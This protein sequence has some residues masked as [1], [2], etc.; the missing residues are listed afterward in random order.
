MPSSL[1]DD[2]DIVLLHVMLNNVMQLFQRGNNTLKLSRKYLSFS[3]NYSTFNPSQQVWFHLFNLKRCFI[4]VLLTTNWMLAVFKLPLR[5]SVCVLM[6]S[7]V[8]YV[9]AAINEQF[10]SR[11]FNT[12]LPVAVF[13]IYCTFCHTA[14]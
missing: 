10:H 1:A 11:I 5:F 8:K 13:F 2:D 9:W 12:E 6:S 14:L 7:Y 4:L 3:E